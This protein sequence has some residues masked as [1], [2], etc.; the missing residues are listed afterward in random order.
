MKWEFQKT[1][2]KGENNPNYQGGKEVPCEQCSKLVYRRPSELKN[3]K[4]IFCSTECHDKFRHKP[5]DP[6]RL[7]AEDMKGE[8]HPR[9]G[10]NKHCKICG[11]V[12]LERK[13]RRAEI[14]SDECKKESVKLGNIKQRI[15]QHGPDKGWSTYICDCCGKEVKAIKSTV[16]GRKYCS[17]ECRYI[18]KRNRVTLE[19]KHCGN[20]FIVAYAREKNESPQFCS[21]GCYRKYQGKTGL[22]TKVLVAIE[23]LG[24]EYIDEYRPKGTRSVFDFYI[25]SLNVL[26]EADGDFWHHSEWAKEQGAH[27]T[28][29]RKTKWAKKNGYK[30]IRLRES[31][32]NEFGALELLK[33]LI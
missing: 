5:K 26:I 7:R 16:Q 9:W 15:T 4:H 1:S 19:C 12:L 31:D 24:L 11:K 18:G 13:E 25:P 2:Y 6:N 20:S 22:E 21:I 3:R 14:C 28:D 23:E 27:K 29:A 33:N 30:L 8:K 32:V 10:G 17:D